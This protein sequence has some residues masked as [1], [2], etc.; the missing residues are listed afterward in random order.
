MGHKLVK[1][2]GANVLVYLLFII[3]KDHNSSYGPAGGSE[4]ILNGNMLFETANVN[5]FKGLF[6]APN[7]HRIDGC[8]S[9]A[10][11]GEPSKCG[12]LAK[13]IFLNVNR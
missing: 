2:P 13:R 11:N 3:E 12:H 10:E 6:K 4:Q 8:E 5:I 1:F 7:H 9:G